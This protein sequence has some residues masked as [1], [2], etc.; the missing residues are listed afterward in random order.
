[1]E[2]WDR[3]RVKTKNTIIIV[4][5]EKVSPLACDFGKIYKIIS[6]S[7]GFI[8]VTESTVCTI[9]DESISNPPKS[10]P[11]GG[12]PNKLFRQLLHPGAYNY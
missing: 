3:G 10:C 8:C 6:C 2:L 1:M 5:S 7:Y 12:T 9:F 4:S 11:S